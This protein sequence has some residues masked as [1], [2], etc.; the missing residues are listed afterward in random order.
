MIYNVP[1]HDLP[2]FC[3]HDRFNINYALTYKRHDRVHNLL[4][5]LLG[6]VFKN[7]EIEPHLLSLDDEGLDPR[8]AN[9]SPETRLDMKADGIW[10]H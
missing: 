2:R 9:I 7:V 3:A 8:S 5:S 6:K 4:I 1:W 10:L